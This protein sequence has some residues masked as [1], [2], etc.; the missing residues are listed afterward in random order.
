MTTDSTLP[1]TTSLVKLGWTSP[2]FGGETVPSAT[3]TFGLSASM[4][5]WSVAGTSST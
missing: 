1:L 3:A 4:V 5:S 2:A